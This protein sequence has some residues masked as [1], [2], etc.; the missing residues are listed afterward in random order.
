MQSS[1]ALF[2][3]RSLIL[4]AAAAIQLAN[5]AARSRA[6]L[7][8]P[9]AALEWRNLLFSDAL[10]VHE[11]NVTAR[12]RVVRW[13]FIAFVAWLSLAWPSLHH[14]QVTKACCKSSRALCLRD[15]SHEANALRCTAAALVQRIHQLS[16][17]ALSR[18]DRRCCLCF[19]ARVCVS[20]AE[21][22]SSSVRASRCN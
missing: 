18:T 16:A 7:R 6:V 17:P 19:F 4:L 5:I 21:N 10:V 1:T 20:K 2:A 13:R 8:R 12:Q 22:E 3:N 15:C 9:I 11:A 14:L